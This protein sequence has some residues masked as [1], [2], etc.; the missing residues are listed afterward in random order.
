MG[1]QQITVLLLIYRIGDIACVNYLEAMVRLLQA[2]HTVGTLK[3]LAIA[4]LILSL[5][6]VKSNKDM[7]MQ[8]FPPCLLNSLLSIKE[9]YKTDKAS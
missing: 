4:G 8:V 6:K 2:R 3:Y 7:L 1:S 9:G 5:I